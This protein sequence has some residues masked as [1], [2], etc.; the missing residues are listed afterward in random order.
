MAAIRGKNTKPEIVVRSMLHRLGFRFRLHKAGL[1]G[2]PDIFLAKYRTA[3]FVHGCFWHVHDCKYGKV[4]PKTNAEFWQN[5]RRSNVER[6]SRNL[7]ALASSGVKPLIVWEC[8]TRDGVTL[9][10]KLVKRL[11]SRAKPKGRANAGLR[12]ALANYRYFCLC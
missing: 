11:R 8:E 5:K 12:F 1:P 10:E 4:V 6:D 2:K 3:I 9:A 7:E